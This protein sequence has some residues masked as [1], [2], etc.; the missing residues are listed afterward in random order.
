MTK[1][2]LIDIKISVS[3]GDYHEEGCI[4][5]HGEIC[6]GKLIG[7]IDQAY[8]QGYEDGKKDQGLDWAKHDLNIN[9]EGTEEYETTS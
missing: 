2:Q 8:T 6:L 1:K 3:R 5:Q 4:C 9:N 7:L